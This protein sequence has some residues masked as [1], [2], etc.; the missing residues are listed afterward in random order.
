MI[1]I[2]DARKCRAR[3]ALAARAQRQH[4]VGGEMAVEVGPAEILH[5]LEAT[6]A[7]LDP[8]APGGVADLDGRLTKWLREHDSH[9]A[10][11]RPDF[12]V[13]GSA[14]SRL[15]P[16]DSQVS[17]GAWKA[18]PPRMPSHGCGAL[19]FSLSTRSHALRTAATGMICVSPA[20]VCETMPTTSPASFAATA[21]VHSGD[22]LAL[23]STRKGLPEG[24]RLTSVSRPSRW[25]MLRSM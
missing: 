5:A 22:T 3:L 11:V 7:S 19:P 1:V 10:L 13:F 12:F 4:L 25:S 21:P 20:T 8:A 14:A 17:S 9:A 15:H 2:G 18:A 6:V 23:A 24:A 16:C